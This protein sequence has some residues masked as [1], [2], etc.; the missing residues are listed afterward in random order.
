MGKVLKNCRD[1]IISCAIIVVI[2]G[3]GFLT[4]KLFGVE[5]EPVAEPASEVQDLKL[6]G[7]VEKEIVTINEVQSKLVEIGELST[8]SSEY[9]VTKEKSFT[10]HVIDNIPIPGT[11][12][13]IHIECEGLVKVGYNI[14]EITPTVD[15]DSQKIYIAI[16]EPQILDN[17]VIWDTVKCTEDNTI[18]NPIDFSQYQEII[19]EIESD[20]LKQAEA[21]GIYEKANEH[22]KLLIQNFLSGFEGYEVVFL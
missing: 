22:L 7:E 6:P 8:Y 13:T 9:Q 11:T 1:L 3:A 5:S 14:D 15:N 17:Y 18:L 16:P 21:A 20:G 12:N 19:D 10:R 4:G 2:F